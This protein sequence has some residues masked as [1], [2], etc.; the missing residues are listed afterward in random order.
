[1]DSI[2]WIADSQGVVIHD[3]STIHSLYTVNQSWKVVNYDI[4]NLNILGNGF[5]LIAKLRVIV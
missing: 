3:I 4:E 1:M 5:G 2:F